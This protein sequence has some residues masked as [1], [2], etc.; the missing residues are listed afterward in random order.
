M[1][2]L[3][4]Q[5]GVRLA[6]LLLATCTSAVMAA[7]RPNVI[8][9]IADDQGYGDLAAHGNPVLRT[10]HMDRLYEE[11]VRFTD[12][13]VAPM[14]SPTRGQLMT[15]MDAMR[16]GCTAVCQGRSMMRSDLP[17]M[18]DYFSDAGYATGHFGKWHLG[19]S[20]PHRPQD[21]GFQETLHHRAWGI[22]SLADY[23]GNTYFDPMLSHNGTDKK[24]PGYC[25]DIFFG[26]AMKWIEE[27]SAR[28]QPFFC[29]LPTNTPHRPNVCDEEY[30]KPYQGKLG[31]KALPAKFYGMIANLDENLGDLEDFLEEKGLREDTLLI[32][33]SD[34]GTQ[35]Q[36]AANVFNAGMRAIKTS[37][38]EGG[39]RVPLFVR[40]P[41]GGLRH[42]RSIDELTQ[43]QDLLPTVIDLCG[44]ENAAK[45]RLD[46][47]SLS[48]LL[49]GESDA[50]PDRKLVVQ[51]RVSGKPWDPAVVMWGKWRMLQ[52]KDSGKN[53]GATR[54]ELY[55]VGH[56][57]GQTENV[58]SAHPRVVEAM[59]E[60]YEQWH[61]EASDLF[62]RRR[63]ITVGSDQSNP[64]M[65]Y[66]Q[67]WVGDYCDNPRGLYASA[68]SGYWNVNVD[69]AG[70]Y[71]VQLRRWPEESN[72]PLTEGWDGAEDTGRSAR[73]IAAAKLGVAGR[74]TSVETDG[75]D[76][77]AAF[78][79][80]L[81]S[82]E[83]RL[84][85]SFLDASGSDLGSAI[86]VKVR[87]LDASEASEV[88]QSGTANSAATP[89][90]DR[91]NIV[92]IFVD[93]LGYGDIGPFG[94]KAN[95]TPNL[96]RM[97]SEGNVLRQFYVANTA[98][99]PSRAALMTGTYAHRIGMDGDVLFPGERRGLN[100]T[101]STIAEVLR[102]R[103]YATGC[104]GKWHLGDQPQ[105]LPLA[106][107]FDRYFGIPYSNDMWPGNRK[108]HRHFKQPYTPL[109]VLAQNKAVAYISDGE[110]QSL[111]CEAVTDHAVDFIES[112]KDTPFFCYVPH[113]SV[114]HPRYVRPELV[115]RAGGDLDR[116]AVEE[117]DS[118]VGRLL[119]TIR[120]LGLGEKTLVIFTSDNGGAHG[121]TMGPLRG[122]KGGPKYEGHMRAPT[123]TWWPGVVPAGVE[124]NEIAVTTDLLPSLARL[125]GAEVPDDRVIDGKDTLDVLLGKP[126]AVSP[127]TVLYYEVDAI[128]RGPWKLV[129]KGPKRELYHLDNDLGE[130][131]DV[132]ATHPDI[133]SE[134]DGLLTAHAKA[135]ESAS[136]PAGFAPPGTAKMLIDEPGSV[137]RLRNYLER[138]ETT[139]STNTQPQ[140]AE[141]PLAKSNAPKEA[142]STR[143]RRPNIVLIV[144]DDQGWNGL[145]TPMDPANPGSGSS[146]FRTP[147]L[148]TLARQG[149]RFSQAYSP[150]PT[151][152]PSRHAI[153]FGRSP[154]SLGIFGGDGI[155]PGEINADPTAALAHCIKRVDPA[156][157]C[158]HLGKWHIAFKPEALGY[159]E[160]AYSGKG[161]EGNPNAQSS[162]PRDPKFIFS[163]T[164]KANAFIETQAETG[165]PFFIQIS[166]YADH[167]RYAA[168]PETVQ[169]YKTQ[170]G[171]DATPYHNDPLWAAMNENLDTGVGM[172]LDKLDELGIADNTYVI[173]TADN[174]FEDKHDFGKP[175]D[176]RGYYKAFPQRSH[177]Y[178]VSEGGVRVPFIIRGPKAPA[179]AHSPAPVAGID[180]FPTVLDIV[181]GLDQA[182]ADVEGGSLLAHLESGNEE[183][184]PRSNPFF[185]FKFTKPRAP[186]D[187][188]IVQGDHKLIKDFATN[189]VF[190]FNLK[191][192]IGEQNNLAT[193]NPDRANRMHA[194][195]T[196]YFARFGWDESRL[197]AKKPRR[198]KSKE[199][200]PQR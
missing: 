5:L 96:D 113:A 42:G 94:N 164:K 55:H 34:N 151:C 31:G 60:H 108:G 23:W 51:Y 63:W 29:Y 169:K 114:H 81:P 121:M 189:S 84:T 126:G 27:Q 183:P 95:Q 174:G 87:R 75:A 157:A 139:T 127:H 188:A 104:F 97:A 66:A 171:G 58:A 179:G 115:A 59:A 48:G 7:N 160:V 100:P 67:D 12:F 111:L 6:A 137:P 105:F 106:Q 64:V 161:P 10:P 140:A 103:G 102:A 168:L 123:I 185:V 130:R 61:A 116:A 90:V 119:D 2:D 49:T 134:L 128:R 83:T 109:P 72:K 143:S 172:V 156:Y 28:D 153:Q 20:Y 120:D 13:H 112:H 38:Y 184:V 199:P 193:A 101:E 154:T 159:D 175:V 129:R 177:K 190:L 92:L 8:L 182:P 192:D 195:M 99:T 91:P 40:W 125:T 22:T 24:Y 68:S 145:S 132:A 17:T 146:Y 197:P 73:P 135:V 45:S 118:S 141:P 35:S 43:V 78:R 62:Q 166:H 80:R 9:I 98:C 178:H 54:T 181:G 85:T 150:A 196:D 79:V 25:T 70:L 152:S 71:E 110:D 155:R 82:G 19:D 186:Y 124:T 117:V 163:L 76:T 194:M 89:P 133:A 56:D 11:S 158:A 3:N 167:L 1:T 138:S 33:L 88:E 57:P 18:A 86:Y 36:E 47:V 191:D 4:R 74:E 37:V 165:R 52:R 149:T 93:D 198:S 44:L 50:L 77:H 176:E 41:A 69:R 131:E 173:Y 144:A 32:Y 170:Y 53:G 180:I 162:D 16:N 26:E 122:G 46:G 187:A 200:A 136:R 30:S 21:R 65:L 148:A 15:G 142:S 14:C 39:H 147:S 107:G